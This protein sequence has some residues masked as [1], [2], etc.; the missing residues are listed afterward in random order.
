MMDSW[1]GF[2]D[3]LRAVPSALR[4]PVR[5]PAVRTPSVRTP[6]ARA[7]LSARTAVAAIPALVGLL[8]SG[9]SG[10]PTDGR[11]VVLVTLDTTRPDRLGT[12]GRP[13]ARTPVLDRLAR[14]GGV[15]EWAIADV[16]VTLPSHTTLMTGIPALGHGVRY[17]ADFK[18]TE[19]A[20]TLAE[21]FSGFG[22]D[23]GAV[24][25]ALVLDSKFGIAQ[26]FATFE[27]DLT[28]GY[29][30][31]DESLYPAETHW[32]PKAD[33]RAEETVDRS[34]EWLDGAR[35]PFF[36][37]SHFYDPHFPFDPP[38]PWAQTAGELYLA[39]IHYTDW[40][41]GRIV[42]AL[43]ESGEADRTVF[44]VTADHGEG[45]DEHREDGHGIF[46]YDD[47]VRVPLII[48][49][50]AHVEAGT[51]IGDQVRTID[52]APTLLEYSG[53][54][55]ETLGIGGTLAPILAGTGPVPDSL[56]YCESIKTRLFYGG[57]GLKVLR[58]RN[59]KFVWAPQ[60]E[61]YLLDEDPGE[62]VNRVADQPEEARGLH[63]RLE[64]V[65]RGILDQGLL[66]VEA[67][68]ADEETLEG[69]RSLGYL[70]GS[71]A[72]AGAQSFEKEME[73]RGH[74]PKDLA[75]VSMG[76][77]EIQNG[78]YENGEKKLLRFFDSVKTP[79]EDPAMAHL[80]AA[81]HQNYAKIWMIRGN[82]HQ[83]AEQYRLAALAEPEYDNARWS[84]IYALNLARE[85]E[86][87][88]REALALIDRYPRSYR[89]M[90]HR[91]VALAFLGQLD[92]ARAQLEEVV[93]DAEPQG[94]AVRNA[95]YYLARLG[96]P[97][98]AEALNGY[99]TAEEKNGG[100]S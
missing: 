80:W 54:A 98:E 91:G 95:R 5:T 34:L 13:D 45:L 33:R 31:F 84:R 51:V 61:L 72:E 14:Q 79:Q 100:Q 53:H 4:R 3:G 36:L 22:Y 1:F 75:D 60:P 41:L 82:Y 12:Y 73:L 2:G 81:A 83:A 37:W 70:A 48:R 6:H 88:N 17:N 52:V 67:Y 20:E 93:R 92:Q 44:A 23:T 85:H 47:T 46:L 57:T 66:S 29:V 78:F 63:R 26:G 62:R 10:S 27:D 71:G 28:P 99:L 50:V 87:A 35:R 96:T 65:V 25:S 55:G 7:A 40:Q 74:D 21:V 30:K 18:V 19:D 15:V 32:L 68:D 90:V 16:P 76:A 42:R 39:E 43:E 77:R 86:L 64:D 59:A 58:T 56:A 38:P 97:R 11:N 9:C 94:T 89:V 24:I 49:D 69:L 8:L